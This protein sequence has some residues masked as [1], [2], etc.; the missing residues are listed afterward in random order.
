MAQSTNVF[1]YLKQAMDYKNVPQDMTVD[2][3]ATRVQLTNKGRVRPLPA[4]QRNIRGPHPSV[5][6]MDEVDE[7]ELAI[8]DG[9]LGQPMPQPNYLGEI[10]DTYT[11]MSSTWQYADGT[12]TEIFRRAET[13]GDPTYRWCFRESSNPID[14][15]LAQKTIDEKRG[16][17]SAEMFRVEYELGEPSIGNRAFDT[18]AVD[19][20]FHIP[21][22]PIETKES[23]DFDEHTFIAPVPGATYVAGADWG[24]EQ[25]YTVI[26]VGRVDVEPHELVYYMRVNR[27]PYPEMIGYFNKAIN[28]YN[29]RAAHDATGLGNV[30]NDYTDV[31]A[32]RFIMTGEK[33]SGM[34]S[35]YVSDIENGAWIFPKIKKAYEE[36]K[37]CQVGDLYSSASAFH[38]PDSVC[39]GALMNRMA[40]RAAGSVAPAIVKRDGSPSKMM[41]FLDGKQDETSTSL[42]DEGQPT[43]TISLLV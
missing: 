38:L 14:G 5:L 7:M 3:T 35:T 42:A 15:W 30:V 25:D 41:A 8:Y 32:E 13:N 6:L 18:Q 43:G 2:Q 40:N 39:A 27:R 20:T 10:V 37:F 21:F 22:A 9:A 33:R 31:R 4:S 16:S 23:K 28:R 12:L 1:E 11:V 34:L 17:I 24:R 26:M 36:M 19:A 29:A